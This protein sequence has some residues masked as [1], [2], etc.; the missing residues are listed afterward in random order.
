MAKITS[1]IVLAGGK[2]K[3]SLKDRIKYFFQDLYYR[4]DRPLYSHT[5]YKPLD[6]KLV[7]TEKR[8]ETEIPL[9]LHKLI[10]IVKVKQLKEIIVVGKKDEITKDKAIK[11]FLK[12]TKKKIIIVDQ[13]EDL[14]QTILNLLKVKRI[15]KATLAYNGVLGYARSIAYK[16][17]IAALFTTVD[18]TLTTTEEYELM[19]K[20]HKKNAAFIYPWVKETELK[21]YNWKH[22]FY[23]KLFEPTKGNDKSHSLSK[24]I[25]YWITKKKRKDNRVG[26]RVASMIL[27]NPLLIKRF[28]VVNTTYYARKVRDLP[29]LIWYF[30]RYAIAFI[31]KYCILFN[32]TMQDINKRA[33]KLL[34]ANGYTCDL[35]IPLSSLDLDTDK[36]ASATIRTYNEL[37]HS[38]PPFVYKNMR[39]KS[40]RYYDKRGNCFKELF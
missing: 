17:K 38:S 33:N 2:R 21:K 16:K 19:L 9:V 24:K 30:G 13:E 14:P 1:A 29:V 26:R 10:N 35:S 11:S 3:L 25:F 5:V 28:N 12:K 34:K 8:K 22:R 6:V 40:V 39:L 20:Q 4:G 27:A 37:R 18:D 31:W 23:L 15:K 32:L 36:D 7:F